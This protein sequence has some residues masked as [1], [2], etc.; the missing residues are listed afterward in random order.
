MSGDISQSATQQNALSNN[1]S[2]SIQEV[3]G[4][5]RESSDKSTSTLVY[6]N[7]VAELADKLERSIDTF[8]MS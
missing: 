4:L 8:K 3:L 1:I 2:H 5:S 6:G 7:Q